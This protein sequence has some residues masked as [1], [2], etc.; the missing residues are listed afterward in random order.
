M[1]CSNT[2]YATYNKPSAYILIVHIYIDESGDMGFTG[3]SSPYFVL[4]ALIV[5]DPLPIRRCFARLRRT[6]LK[7]KYRE[8][9]EFKF[10]NSSAEIKRRILSCIASADVGICFCVLRKKQVH[11]HLRSQHQI[12]YNYLTGVLISTIISKYRP[13]DEI[14]ITVDKS[15]NGIQRE[16]FN[17]YLVFKTMEKNPAHAPPLPAIRIDHADSESETCIQA[18]DFVAG[19]LH[20]QYREDDDTY[21]CIIDDKITIALDFFKGV[22]KR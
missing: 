8:L 9:P 6:K 11:R 16:A 10:N 22:Q 1:L 18:V 7:K 21:R 2:Q 17:Q 3:R 4:A 13:D 12:V 14:E 5:N 19:A 15:L 20:Y